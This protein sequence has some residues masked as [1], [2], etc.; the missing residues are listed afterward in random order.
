MVRVTIALGQLDRG[1]VSELK[2]F[3]TVQLWI[4]QLMTAPELC[5]VHECTKVISH[6]GGVHRR[7]S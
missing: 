4:Q 3:H 1:D 7:D 5:T 2:Q 6:V